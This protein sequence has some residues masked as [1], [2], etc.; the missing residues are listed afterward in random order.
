MLLPPMTM[1]AVL[2]STNVE[3][4][5]VQQPKRLRYDG[6]VLDECGVAAVRALLTEHV[7]VTATLLIA[8]ANAVVM[9][10]LVLVLA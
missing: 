7:T 1:A 5:A 9:A 4:V 6:N 10:L 2:N 3:F 8:V